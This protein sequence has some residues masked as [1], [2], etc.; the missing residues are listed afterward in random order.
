M[1]GDFANM[2]LNSD[3]LFFREG[4]FYDTAVDNRL[5]GKSLIS[6]EPAF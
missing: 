5:G 6:R 4:A 1:R 2:S 3:G